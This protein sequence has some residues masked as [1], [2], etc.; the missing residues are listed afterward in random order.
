MEGETPMVSQSGVGDVQRDKQGINGGG[1]RQRDR[2][3]VMGG[4][5]AGLAAARV[6]SRHYG[7]VI[8]VERD[9]FGEVG[10]HRRGVPQGR[11]AH[12]LLASGLRTLE[13]FFPGLV[14]EAINAG[15]LRIDVM[16]DARFCFEGREQVRF[17]SGLDGLLISRPLFEGLVRERVRRTPN[18]RC[19]DGCQV[20]GLIATPDNRRVAGIKTTGDTLLADL[21]VDATGRGSHSPIWLEEMG[22]DQ[23]KVERIEINLTYVTRRFRRSPHHLG[24]ASLA[25][26]AATPE[27]KKFGVLIAQE[28]DCWIVSLNAYGEVSVPAELTAFIEFAKTLPA[29]YIYDVVSQ[30][31][32]I[33]EAQATRFP[34]SVRRRYEHMSRFPE[35]Y[36]V[37]GDAVSS[38]NPAYG[39]GMS[40]AALEAVELDKALRGGS[41]D[42]ARRFFAQIARIVDVPWG[43]AA[44][45]DLRMPG[46]TGRRTPMTRF[47]NWY[48]AKVHLAAQHDSSVA[49]AFHKVASLLVPP[50]SLFKPSVITRVLLTAPIARFASQASRRFLHSCELAAV[51]CARFT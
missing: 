39:Q 19:R 40:V 41:T 42:L 28:G 34:A 23:P 17:E 37:L 20:L 30:A 31:E 27:T 7:E 35:G 36:L 21:V 33:G 29:S 10:E 4:S 50:Q 48:V 1:T 14:R 13:G 38:F 6:L 47:F 22:Y 5:M 16:R 25:V 43:T 46:V 49:M 2:A 12:G 8:L 32:P 3:I 44:G 9:R 11:H 26:I 45:N 24:G 15:A 51:T 18:V